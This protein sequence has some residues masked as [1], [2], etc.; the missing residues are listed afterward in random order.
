MVREIFTL[1]EKYLA[2]FGLGPLYTLLFHQNWCN[3][4][5]KK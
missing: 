4:E 3:E 5:P 2:Y 1:S